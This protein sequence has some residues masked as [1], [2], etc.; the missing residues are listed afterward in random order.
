MKPVFLKAFRGYGN[1]GGGRHPTITF[2]SEG[3]TVRFSAF[4]AT[5]VITALV[6][7][8]SWAFDT[9][10]LSIVGKTKILVGKDSVEVFV[11]KKMKNEVFTQYEYYGLSGGAELIYGYQPDGKDA[12][13]FP[14]PYTGLPA[15]PISVNDTWSGWL[16]MPTTEK[17]LAKSTAELSGKTYPSLEILISSTENYPLVSKVHLEGVGLLGAE[18]LVKGFS[19]YSRLDSFTIVG[20][21]GYMPF[22]V[23]NRWHWIVSDSPITGVAE[24]AP[25][26]FILHPAAPNPFNPS[27]VIRY[28]IPFTSPVRLTVYDVLGREV[29]VLREG[30]LAPGSYSSVWDGRDRNGAVMGSGVYLYRLQAGT[31]TAAGKVMFLR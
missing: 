1:V 28:E 26:G 23:G 31:L 30:T 12:V 13:I 11:A 7:S 8:A 6:S 29:T 14:T 25:R 10:E 2:F 22:A 17:V 4:A 20:G 16:D 15:D 27:T 19:Y 5:A 3:M 18:S 9:E 24:A 21:S